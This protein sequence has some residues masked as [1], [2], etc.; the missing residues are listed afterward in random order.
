MDTRILYSLA[1][2]V[3]LCSSTL[4]G[5]DLEILNLEGPK[6]ALPGERIGTTVNVNVRNKS[7]R[8]IYENVVVNLLLSRDKRVRQHPPLFSKSFREDGIIPGGRGALFLVQKNNRWSKMSGVV[9]PATTKPGKYYLVAVAYSLD[10]RKSRTAGRAYSFW[11]LWVRNPNNPDIV[12]YISKSG[13]TFA[14]QSI[15]KGLY[16]TVKNKGPR[17]A[18]NFYV[19]LQLSRDKELPPQLA[20]SRTTFGEDMLLPGGRATVKYLGPGKST[21]I[22]FPGSC[23]VP[24][25]IKRGDYHLF[26][27]ADAGNR[28]SER[29]ELNNHVFQ[30]VRLVPVHSKPDLVGRVSLKGKVTVKSG[31]ALAKRLVVTVENK[32]PVAAGKFLVEVL[33]GRD[34]RFPLGGGKYS[35]TFT[36][37]CILHGGRGV[38]YGLKPG[39]KT[40]VKMKGAC[41]VPYTRLH[42]DFNLGIVIDPRNSVSEIKENNNTAVYRV[43]IR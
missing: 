8:V 6:Q 36:E 38:V 31:E 22:N 7:T 33:L 30:K 39:Q 17:A 19:D 9:I 21:R 27:N 40:R 43:R 2:A 37:D 11:P 28:V 29:N 12:P 3:F 15:K 32:G 18:K 5:G 24:K 4:Y 14:G 25:D 35:K 23:V 42:G 13:K 1:V 26:V 10:K 41:L 34:V 16:V 20:K